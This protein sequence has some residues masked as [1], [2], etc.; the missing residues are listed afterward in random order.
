M[1]N[2]IL[3]NNIDLIFFSTY[4]EY[5]SQP[6]VLFEI[7]FV[8]MLIII[9]VYINNMNEAKKIIYYIIHLIYYLGLY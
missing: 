3:Y 2:M 8:I 6:K 1:L 9:E 4:F 7:L 5:I